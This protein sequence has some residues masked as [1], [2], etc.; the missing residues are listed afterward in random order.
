MLRNTESRSLARTAPR[1]GRTA[2]AGK[3]SLS[4][5]VCRALVFCLDFNN[6]D[7]KSA[8]LL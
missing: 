4:R 2:G 1:L 7:S 8:S 3:P 6:R 5:D